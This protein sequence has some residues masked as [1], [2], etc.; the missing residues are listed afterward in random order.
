MY[1]LRFPFLRYLKAERNKVHRAIIVSL[2]IAVIGYCQSIEQVR[3]ASL[4]V[5]LRGLVLFVPCFIFLP[6][7]LH[8]AGIWLAMPVAEC[9]TT[10]LIVLI[11]ARL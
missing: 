11:F 10:L 9:M 4:F 6:I 5:L 3:K 1:G 8:D 2:N 7:T